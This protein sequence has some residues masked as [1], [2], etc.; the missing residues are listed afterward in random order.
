[1]SEVTF[2]RKQLYDLVWS[3]SLVSLSKRYNISDSGLRKACKRLGIP[4]PDAGHWNKVYAGKKVRVKPFL[5]KHNGEQ[6]LALSLRAE[7]G[8]AINAGHSAQLTLQREIEADESLDLEVRQELADPDPLVKKALRSFSSKGENSGYLRG[9]LGSTGPGNLFINVSPALLDRSLLF[10]DAF[11]KAM[12]QRG[13]DFTCESNFYKV[14]ISGEEI[15]MALTEAQNRIPTGDRW[16]STVLKANGA[17]VFKFE[18]RNISTICKDGKEQKIEQQL[19]KLIARLELMAERVKTAREELERW[20]ARMSEEKAVKKQREERKQLEI[21]S[22]QQ[23]VRDAGRWKESEIVREYINKKERQ[24]LDEGGMTDELSAWIEWARKKVDWYD[25]IVSAHDEWLDD[26]KPSTIMRT[27]DSA[28]NV[29]LSF[30][31]QGSTGSSDDSWPLKAW[32]VK[33]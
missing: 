5:E 20:W 19:S 1:M 32:Y 27:E 6:D 9:D 25:P 4:L 17:L 30:N 24:A 21:K 15:E 23:L 10:M 33:S 7:E 18:E 16:Q 3:E 2:S 12:R 13:H 31:Q 8:N 29:N 14:V 11:V 26:S 28:K 22:F